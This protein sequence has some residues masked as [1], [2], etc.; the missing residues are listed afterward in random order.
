MNKFLE[1]FHSK[2]EQTCQELQKNGWSFLHK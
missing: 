2:L 1:N